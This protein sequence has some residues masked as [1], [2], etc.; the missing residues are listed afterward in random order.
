MLGMS[1]TLRM[2]RRDTEADGRV[3]PSRL[4]QSPLFWLV[5]LFA[6]GFWLYA[7]FGL[8]WVLWTGDEREYADIARRLARGEG[9]TTAI[10]YPALTPF[11]VGADHPSLVRPPMWPAAIAA[12]FAITGPRDGV[13]LAA[14]FPFY[15]GTV[16]AA[17]AMATAMANRR[18][19]VLAGLAVASSPHVLLYSLLAGTEMAFAFWTTLAFL[20]LAKKREPLWIGAACALAY[21]T[22]YNS[23]VILSAAMLLALGPSPLRALVRFAIGFALIVSPWWVRNWIV[24][25]DPFFTLLSWNLHFDPGL[26]KPSAT[27]FHMLKPDP[28][29]AAA[30]DPLEKAAV[31]LPYLVRHSPFVNTNPIAFVGVALACL[32]RDRLSLAFAVLA[33]AVTGSIAFMLA[34]GRYFAP[35]FPVMLALGIVGWARY[36]GWLRAP[37]LLLVLLTP[38]CFT[39]MPGKLAASGAVPEALLDLGRTLG[40][41]FP[42]ELP[43]LRHYRNLLRIVRQSVRDGSIDENPHLATRG[44][45]VDCLSD[46]RL[47]V[48]EDAARVAWYADRPT[49]WLTASPED[50]WRVVDAYPV[51]AVW[52]HYRRDILSEKFDAVF[53]PRPECAEGFYQRRSYSR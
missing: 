6:V 40:R 47:I 52:I 45:W 27:L 15:L 14:V 18:V 39:P 49:L 3:E 21:L 34:L 17:A 44:P 19:G 29:S 12:A 7:R 23:L 24:T 10:I 26:T 20:L 53:R 2:F 43:D 42:Q 38:L 4:A 30:R 51:D 16:V 32:R 37:A 5:V 33:V 28:S 9:F 36:G 31:Q 50:F 8:P 25:G 22:R 1:R 48:A 35:L 11:G 13:A 41:Y 46:A